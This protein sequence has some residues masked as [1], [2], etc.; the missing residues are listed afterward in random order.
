MGIAKRLEEIYFPGDS[1]PLYIDKNSESLRV[2]QHMR[3]EAHRFGITFHRNK[4]SK[5]QVKSALDSIPGI[6]PKSR[7]L[8]LSH[9]KSVKRIKEASESDLMAVVGTAKAKIIK[10]YLI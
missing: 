2:I 4:R 9:F 3:D 5:G 10:K 8:L 7:D 1:L 6:C